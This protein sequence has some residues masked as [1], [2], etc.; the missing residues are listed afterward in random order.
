MTHFGKNVDEIDDFNEKINFSSE[1]DNV[2][3]E[4]VDKLKFTGF[5]KVENKELESKPK[6]KKEIYEE[7]IKK[8]KKAKFERQ[9]QKEEDKVK[10]EEINSGF[11]DIS[12]LLKF[13]Q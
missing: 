6:S 1:E 3:A 5:E 8:S 10:I 12:G 2:P 13:R 7:I 4:I 9:Q 11:S